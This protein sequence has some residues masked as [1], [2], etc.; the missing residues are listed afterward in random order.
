[1]SLGQ[2]KVS[3]VDTQKWMLPDIE[4]P[5]ERAYKYVIM[6]DKSKWCI[7]CDEL[8]GTKVVSRDAIK[9]RSLPGARPWLAGIVKDEMCA[10]IH[11]TELLNIFRSG[12]DMCK[13]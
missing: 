4:S 13:E 6:L 10:L 1:M 3:V 2:D 9:W 7:G 8:I 11:V 5:Q 12:L